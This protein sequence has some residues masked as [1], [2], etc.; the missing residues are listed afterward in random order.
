MT[1]TTGQSTDAA[2]KGMHLLVLTLLFLEEEK[3][4]KRKKE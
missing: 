1:M 3:T 4:E 2:E